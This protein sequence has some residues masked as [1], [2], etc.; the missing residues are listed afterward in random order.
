[1]RS[2]GRATVYPGCIHRPRPR[3]VYS[4]PS[5]KEAAARPG[6]AP[7]ALR[8]AA[9]KPASCLACTAKPPVEEGP[10]LRPAAD[11]AGGHLRDR[12]GEREN[13][14]TAVAGSLAAAPP[15]TI[16]DR[17]RHPNP[18]WTRGPGTPGAPS[19][20]GFSRSPQAERPRRR[21]GRATPPPTSG[22]GAPLHAWA[23]SRRRLPHGAPARVGAGASHRCCH[24]LGVAAS[25]ARP[26]QFCT[27][28]RAIRWR[29]LLA[30]NFAWEVHS[31]PV[32]IRVSVA[33][34][35]CASDHALGWD[36]WMRRMM[37]HS[38]RVKRRD[39]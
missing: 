13:P 21:V 31:R 10:T 26:A 4:G 2:D 25:V 17:S 18:R 12:F 22:A 11:A 36:Q 7:D 19:V 3:G 14:A 28:G 6:P 16:H 20:T 35:R 30:R 8:L 5:S 27:P 33:M 32:R 23:C 38:M 9:R 15:L 24:T 39:Q 29:Y 34:S 1:M 37:Q